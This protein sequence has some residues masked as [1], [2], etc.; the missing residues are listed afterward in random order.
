MEK[1]FPIAQETQAMLTTRCQEAYEHLRSQIC[2]GRLSPGDRLLEPALAAELQM[3]RAPLREALHQLARDGLVEQ[4]PGLGTFVRWPDPE[5][6]A[7]ICKAREV[8]ETFT[9]RV[10]AE[11]IRDD[12]LLHLVDLT[13]RM[14]ALVEHS[15]QPW[16]AEQREALLENE[17]DFHLSIAQAA[18][19]ATIA[20][21]IEGFLTVQFIVTYHPQV[22]ESSS[23]ET[24]R[25]AWERHVQ[26]VEALSRHDPD[27]T[28][29]SMRAH[30]DAG[31]GKAIAVCRTLHP[32]RSSST[33][34]AGRSRG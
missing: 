1:L 5:E 25:F 10:A 3:S 32:R 21:L 23:M 18:G 28:V 15:R 8:L 17:L 14:Q 34:L 22:P 29:A 4:I 11:R 24:R 13:G 20:R 9:A 12:Q 31:A 26:L 27:A 16:D 33:R 7:E 19:N 2:K 30:I 6:L